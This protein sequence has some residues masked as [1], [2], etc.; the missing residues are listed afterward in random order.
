MKN[1]SL[2]ALVSA[3][4]RAYHAEYNQHPVFNDSLARAML[5]DEEYH[6]IGVQMSQGIGFFLPDFK[7]SQEEALRAVVDFQLSPTP[8]GRAAFTEQA[9]HNAVMLGAG[10]YLIL[11]A[12]YDTFAY[13][14]PEW[15]SQLQIYEIDH[16]ATAEDKRRRTAELLPP[17][18][19]NVHA[20]P[21][22]LAEPRWEKLLLAAPEFDPSRISFSSLLGI[23]YYLTKTEFEQL[24]SV[25]AELLPAGSS[26][27]FDYPDGLTFTPEAGE[28]T[29]KQVMM[30]A[31]AGEPM[32]ASYTYPELEQLL[33]DCGLLIYRH[34]TPP[35]ITRELFQAYNDKQPEYPLSAFDNVNYCLAV[36]R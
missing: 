35:E 26:F 11:G 31:R 13:R 21:A 12:G 8:L 5:T 6:N 28:R 15:A 1:R 25:L 18:P 33:E 23:S 32:Q 3:F 17:K 20:V 9:L 34:L 10:Q 30:A 22:D 14:Q 19:A 7:G 29:Q 36:K 2:T 4:A 24:L 27:A 16:P